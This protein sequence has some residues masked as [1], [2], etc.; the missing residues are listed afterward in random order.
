MNPNYPTSLDDSTTLPS[1]TDDSSLTSPDL[2]TVQNTQN[3]AVIALETKVGTGASTPVANTV[4]RGTG[5]GTTAYE[6][7][8]LATDVTGN[9]PVTNLDS[10][11]SASSTTF[12]RGD[13][14]WATPAG[15][16][17]VSGPSTSTSGDVAAF[18]DTTGTTIEDSG[19]AYTSLVTLTGTQTLT[20]KTLQT[21]EADVM[22][23]N[24]NPVWQYLGYADETTNL[25]TSSGTD[26]QITDLTLTVTVP[27]GVTVV[28]ITAS[29]PQIYNTTSG[30]GTTLK[31]WRGTVGT[32]TQLAQAQTVAGA[33]YEQCMTFF[34]I[35][36]PSAGS[37][38]YNVSFATLGGGEV[39]TNSGTS[40]PSFILVEAC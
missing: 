25:T 26:S 33:A 35:D 22:T 19:I 20:N 39:E 16:G 1:A 30:A 37:V 21:N 17:N 40:S 18:S 8:D 34:A 13:G 5:T 15:G 23:L 29:C 28:R 2:A 7:V 31:I 4:L 36:T 24:S 32:G 3:A 11:T 10:G 38:T 6:Q 9:L 14:T 12:W 27:T